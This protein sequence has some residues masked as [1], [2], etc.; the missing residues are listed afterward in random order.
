VKTG[1]RLLR[2]EGYGKSFGRN[3]V[4]KSASLWATSGS[5]TVLLGSNGSGKTTLLRCMLGVTRADFGVTHF[6]GLAT[7]RPRLRRLARQGLFY[8]PDRH[9]LPRA[10]RFGAMMR[11]VEACRGTNPARAAILERL[12][13]SGLEQHKIHQMS[14]GEQRRCEWGL[15]LLSRPTCLVADE[16][17]AGVTPRDQELVGRL[18]RDAAESG[19]AVIVTGHEVH[20][21]LAL[22]DEIVW[23]A[24]GTTHGL[25]SASQARA[26]QQFRREYLGPGSS[27]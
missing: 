26:H 1:D 18:L 20:E 9:F 27:A 15:A 6:Q 14:G 23:M 25:G 10:L 13:I 21:L 5:I 7:E 12:G 3:V 4:L 19:C 17:L 11:A 2:A 24:A 16:P 8:L 22:G